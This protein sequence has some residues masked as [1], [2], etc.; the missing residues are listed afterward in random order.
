MSDSTENA[1][2]EGRDLL[3]ATCLADYATTHSAPVDLAEFQR[4]C[5]E[6]GTQLHRVDFEGKDYPILINRVDGRASSVKALMDEYRLRPV[7][8]TGIANVTTLQSFINLSTRHKTEHSAIFANVDWT[9]PSLT[10]V[11]DYHEDRQGGDADNGKHRIHYAF[12]LSEEWQ[13]WVGVNGKPMKQGEF[14][15]FIEDH[16]AELATPHEEEI[17][18]WEALIGGKV[19][20]PNDIQMLSRGLKINAETKLRSNTVLAT[21]EGELTWEEEHRDTA[22]QK[23]VVPS[24]FIV[25]L[26]PFFRG[27]SARIPTRLRYRVR[28]GQVIWFF[29]LYRPDVYIT[30][31][32]ERDL[33]RAAAET[34]L[35]HFH[36]TPEMSA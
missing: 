6:A 34:E 33:D 7:A 28:E 23:L 36:G 20:R 1:T 24:L 13:A 30:E 15:E 26:P 5:N 32:V 25:Q 3:P 21:G 12:P 8:K 29:Q 31:Q 19:A 4:L 2:S 18:H 35:P 11:I 10:T 22:G 27:E 14:A 17:T 16:I 9:K